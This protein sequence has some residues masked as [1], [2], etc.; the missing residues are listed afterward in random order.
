MAKHYSQHMY[1]FIIYSLFILCILCIFFFFT[2]RH[3]KK[4]ALEN[5]AKDLENMCASVE[6]SVEI[7]LDDISTISMNLVYSNTIKTNFKEF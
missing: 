5:A 4:N 3:Y 7:Q 2:Y 6:N 1:L